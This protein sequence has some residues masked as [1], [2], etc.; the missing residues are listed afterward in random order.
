LSARRVSSG[1]EA[2]RFLF[3]TSFPPEKKGA[4]WRPNPDFREGPTE[5]ARSRNHMEVM[6][7]STTNAAI[8]VGFGPALTLLPGPE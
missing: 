4:P 7:R 3:H 1:R 8:T 5:G 2:A 6:T